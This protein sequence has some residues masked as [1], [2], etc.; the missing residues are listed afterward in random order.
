MPIVE[1]CPQCELGLLRSDSI[2]GAFECDMCGARLAE[3]PKPHQHQW[4][5]ITGDNAGGSEADWCPTCESW[6]D[7]A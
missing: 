1:P 7:A 3:I 4:Q 5:R 2:E 6:R